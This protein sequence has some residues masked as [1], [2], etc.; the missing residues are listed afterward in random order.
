MASARACANEDGCSEDAQIAAVDNAAKVTEDRLMRFLQICWVKYVKAKIEPGSTAGAVGAQSIGEP[1]T[2]MTL[3]T[4]HF[5]GVAS[6]NVT[7]GVPRIKEIINASK[8]I[9][10]PIISCKL[11]ARD[12]E[13]SARI[14]K[15]RL[16]KTH[17]GDIAWAAEYIYI[18]IIIDTEAIRKLQLDLTLD[19][20]KWAIV[21]AKK[22]KIKEHSV[23]MLPK[24]NR[25]RVYV[26]VAKGVRTLH[27]AIIDIK[28]K[29]D[30]R[31]QKGD[32]EFLIEEGIIGELTTWN[33]VIEFTMSEYGMNIDL[34]HMMLLGDVMTYK[35]EVLGITR[36]GVAKMKDSVLMLASFE[37]TTYHLFDASVYGKSDSIAGVSES[38]IMGNAAANCGTSMP[39]LYMPAPAISK[40]RKLLF[41]GSL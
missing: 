6:M 3:K 37:K 20:I 35:G 1:G 39:A 29:D 22:L 27:R 40:H 12:S 25:L 15:G 34:R 30:T 18:G 32:K 14:V 36:F 41:E 13:S 11:T 9:G 24:K 28:D 7:Q 17:L 21:N 2:Q 38:I 4:F 33:H 5:A 31:G 19:D 10:T 16:E 26:D 8:D 23:I